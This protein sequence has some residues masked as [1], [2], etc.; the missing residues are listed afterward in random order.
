MLLYLPERIYNKC[1]KNDSK[2]QEMLKSIYDKVFVNDFVQMVINYNTDNDYLK[3]V[4]EYIRT[5]VCEEYKVEVEMCLEDDLEPYKNKISGY[6]IETKLYWLCEYNDGEMLDTEDFN[7][8]NRTFLNLY[9]MYV[10]PN[11]T[12]YSAFIH[13]MYY[14]KMLYNQM[15]VQPIKEVTIETINDYMEYEESLFNRMTAMIPDESFHQMLLSKREHMA[16]LYYEFV[17]QFIDDISVIER[18]EKLFDNEAYKYHSFSVFSL[19]F[20]NL[21]FQRL[22]DAH[23]VEE[24]RKHWMK[25]ASMINKAF[26]DKEF[27]IKSLNHYNNAFGEWFLNYLKYAFTIEASFFTN[28]YI[29][30]IEKTT[31]LEKRFLINDLTKDEMKQIA[32]YINNDYSYSIDWAQSKKYFLSLI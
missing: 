8:R 10:E 12:E 1:F 26:E 3:Q 11:P 13:L 20:H 17:G 19:M 23:N 4:S 14:T 32:T 29:D 15:V 25:I 7:S 27:A 18:L 2:Y 9:R 31:T 28:H 30:I 21:C 6:D 22:L 5:N 24:A 16:T